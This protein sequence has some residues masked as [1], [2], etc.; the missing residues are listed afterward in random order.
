MGT[1]GDVAGR[2]DFEKRRKAL[3]QQTGLQHYVVQAR[4]R[5]SMALGVLLQRRLSRCAGDAH[6]Q[7]NARQIYLN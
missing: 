6:S 7:W 3:D 5:S 4:G 2:K 1:E